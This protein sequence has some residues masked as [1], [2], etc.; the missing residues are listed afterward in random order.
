MSL[1]DFLRPQGAQM[2]GM[3]Q[4]PSGL[5]RILQPEVAL[6]MAA[7]L[8]GNQGNM[9]NFGNALGMAGQGLQAQKA[10]QK[11]QAE[12]NKTLEFF[13]SKAPE[14]AEMVAS[15]MPIGDAWKTYT[16][17]KYAQ[18][19][20]PA[21]VQE[22]EYAKNS[23]AFDGT[24]TD[25]QTK[26]IREQDPTFGRE[27]ELRGQYDMDPNVKNY[28]VVR[29]NYERIREGATAGT[30]AGDI[31]VI[32]GYMKMLDPTSVVRENEQATAAN[33]GGVPA[34]IRNLYNKT[35]NGDLLPP[36][37]R[38][39]IVQ[40]AD[41]IYQQTAGNVQ[42]TNERYSGVADRYQLDRSGIIQEPEVYKP[43]NLGEVKDLGNGVTI[44][45]T[46]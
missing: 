7:A 33:A 31:S 25:W 44:R 14:Y 24:F 19:K 29:D 16:E 43:L 34:H 42:D 28:K 36:E 23:G 6:P 20:A 30:G 38:A 21:S 39:Q 40:Q 8:L 10:E 27:K 41:A 35:M 12:L 22:Y 18:T 26:G 32:F 17:Q 2:P 1:L 11:K 37:S 4:Q 9:Q 13:K 5:A 46:K 15:G 3:A 45:K